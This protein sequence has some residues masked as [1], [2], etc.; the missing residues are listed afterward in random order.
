MRFGCEEIKAALRMFGGAN[1][2]VVTCVL[3]VGI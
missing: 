3:E 2:K 1:N